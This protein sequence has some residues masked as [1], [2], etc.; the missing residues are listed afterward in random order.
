MREPSGRGRG[1]H[2]ELEA[3]RWHSLTT[4]G[5]EYIGKRKYPRKQRKSLK[6]NRG[7]RQASR[8]RGKKYTGIEIE[9]H[10]QKHYMRN[11]SG[12]NIIKNIVKDINDGLC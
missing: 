4:T 3:A 8:A 9:N 11:K 2:R 6:N 10:Y 1:S 5:K 7:K 12:K